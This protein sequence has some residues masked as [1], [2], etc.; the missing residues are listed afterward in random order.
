MTHVIGAACID[1]KDNSCIEV[2]PVDCISERERMRVIDPE[3]CID[4]GACVPECPVEAIY[5]IDDLPVEWQEFVAINA[6]ASQGSDLGS[7]LDAYELTRS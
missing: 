4:C 5:F 7:L 6:A 1:V 2:C 3:A